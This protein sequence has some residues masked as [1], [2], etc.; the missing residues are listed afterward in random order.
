MQQFQEDTE[1]IVENYL[2]WNNQFFEK[3]ICHGVYK[4]RM[5]YFHF[6]INDLISFSARKNKKIILHIFYVRPRKAKYFLYNILKRVG[7]GLCEWTGVARAQKMVR[8]ELTK[9]VNAMHNVK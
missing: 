7:G 2:I 5:P 6:H 9:I 1:I 4:K 3:R 8:R